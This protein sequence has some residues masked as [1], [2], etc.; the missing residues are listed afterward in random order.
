MEAIG[1]EIYLL[2]LSELAKREREVRTF[3][4]C[5]RV[6]QRTSQEKGIEEES[7]DS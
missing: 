7:M 6:A 5:I 3:E 4:E 1:D 2:G